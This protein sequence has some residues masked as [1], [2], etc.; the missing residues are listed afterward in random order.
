MLKCR[1]CGKELVIVKDKNPYDSDVYYIGF[2]VVCSECYKKNK[3][4]N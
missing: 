2:K 4:T 1:E 3:E